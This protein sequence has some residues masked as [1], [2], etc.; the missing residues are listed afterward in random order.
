MIFLQPKKKIDPK[1]QL[2]FEHGMR[3]W[4]NTLISYFIREY[5]FPLGTHL[6]P[7][8]DYFIFMNNLKL[9]YENNLPLEEFNWDLFDRIVPD[10]VCDKSEKSD[11]FHMLI[12]L[13]YQVLLSHLRNTNPMTFVNSKAIV[14]R[15]V[16][17]F[18]LCPYEEIPMTA[19]K[20]IE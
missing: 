15:I 16:K 3:N 4:P 11:Y 19:V 14:S 8:A 12:E 20:K 18:L 10:N 9:W 17:A 6:Y 2:V 1:S 7:M 5:E 13:V